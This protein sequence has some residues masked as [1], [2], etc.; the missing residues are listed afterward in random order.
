M[1]YLLNFNKKFYSF[2]P[3]II[4]YDLSL[5]LKIFNLLDPQIHLHAFYPAKSFEEGTSLRR[6]V[7]ATQLAKTYCFETK[8][9]YKAFLIKNKLVRC[10]YFL[11]N[12]EKWRVNPNWAAV[13]ADYLLIQDSQ[14]VYWIM[15]L[16]GTDHENTIYE[17]KTY[18]FI[19]ITGP[20]NTSFRFYLEHFNTQNH[21]Y[22]KLFGYKTGRILKKLWIF[23]TK[24]E[25]AHKILG[26][27]K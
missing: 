16:L 23:P 8:E 22:K 10:S 15:D 1:Y 19:S 17:A 18:I 2:D 26:I 11:N 27:R 3:F 6:D 9:A 20:K 14:D 25:L 5:D 21:T 13:A 4:P 7:E 12:K 24:K